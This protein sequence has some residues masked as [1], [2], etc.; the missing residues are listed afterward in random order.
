MRISISDRFFT[1]R[2]PLILGL[3]GAALG[4]AFVQAHWSFAVLGGMVVVILAAAENEAFL[5]G[6]VFLIPISWIAEIKLPLGGD[7]GRLDVATT[8][9]L[10]VI[11]GFIAGR[12]FRDAR[13][14][15]NSLKVPLTRLSLLFAAVTFASLILGGYGS[16][17]SALKAGVRL[18]S[19]I[20]F[21]LIVVLWVDSPRPRR[22][23][24]LTLM[25]STCF[26]AGFAIIQELIGGYTPLWFF[27]NPPNEFFEPWEQRAPSFFANCNFL[28]G[29]LN[30]VLPFALG[31]WVLG[32][33]RWRKLGAWATALGVVALLCTQS[34]GGVG[35]FCAV[36]CLAILCFV[37]GWKR[38][39]ALLAAVCLLMVGFYSAKAIF[40]PAH[41]GEA[42]AYD[43]S[44]RLVLWGIAWNFFVHSPIFGVGWGNFAELYG[45][46][47]TGISWLQEGRYEVHN[48]YLQLLSETGLVGFG[49]FFLLIFAAAR[50]AFRQ[51]RC[52]LQALDK[53][54][55]F[56]VL[57]AILTVLLHGFVDFFFQVSPQYGTV[58]WALLALLVVGGMTMSRRSLS[59]LDG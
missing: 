58:F 40:S 18:L 12:L 23:V 16:S 4:A 45:S 52:S 14:I 15:V 51:L 42:F 3:L 19:Y 29:Y 39:F 9:R 54:L 20:G 57:G 1:E 36:V 37:A 30:L 31:C 27:L 10:L 13:S 48:I 8:L 7:A 24:L 43:Q 22:R 33:G 32:E 35:A 5:L 6:V 56:G 2:S 53:A 28:A 50:Q 59:E 41:E 49:A 47:V 26:V 11:A 55:A 21:Y 44:I 34:L 38:K 17:Y 25:I 46:S